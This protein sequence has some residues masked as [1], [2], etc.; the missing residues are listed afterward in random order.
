VSAVEKWGDENWPYTPEEIDHIRKLLSTNQRQ[1]VARVVEAAKLYALKSEYFP[2][3]K[4]PNPRREIENLTSAI[5]EL[6]K[7][8][9]AIS[10][11]AEKHLEARYLQGAAHESP[12]HCKDLWGAIIKFTVENRKG[13]NEPAS[14]PRAGAIAKNFERSLMETFRE[15]FD[16]SR[17]VGAITRGWPGFLTACAEPLQRRHKLP[18]IAVKSWQDKRRKNPSGKASH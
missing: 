12:M 4:K 13:L 7:A 9:S 3:N 17:D 8:L 5:I 18:L 16:I 15:A 2:A 10:P 11:D 6:R 14:V 1:A